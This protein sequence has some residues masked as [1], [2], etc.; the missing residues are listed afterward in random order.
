MAE[1]GGIKGFF[2]HS[3]TS[4]KMNNRILYWSLDL[5]T[6]LINGWSILVYYFQFT[7]SAGVGEI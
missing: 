4:S 7:N 5:P 2:Y 3:K 1:Y 6:Y